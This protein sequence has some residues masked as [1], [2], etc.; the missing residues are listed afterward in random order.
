VCLSSGLAAELTATDPADLGGQA[1]KDRLTRRMTKI[2]AKL[3]DAAQRPARAR[4]DYSRAYNGLQKFQHA[5]QRGIIRQ[6]FDVQV[7][8]QLISSS[9]ALMTQVLTLSATA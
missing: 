3:A 4:R 7:A 1:R 6:N 2:Q 9:A 5:L 8:N